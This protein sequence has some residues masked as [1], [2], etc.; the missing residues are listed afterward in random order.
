MKLLFAGTPEF[1]AR[2][3]AA[4]AESRH[5]ITAIITRPDKPGKRGRK[6]VTCAVGKLAGELHIP[7]LQ[8]DR[9]RL[10]HIEKLDA[11]LLVVVAYGQIL[12]EDILTFPRLGCINVHASLLPRWRGAAPIQRAIMAGDR[13]T[14]IC[15]MKMDAGL[16]TGD[17]Y[18]RTVV[19]ILEDDTGA[20][21]SDRL[22]GA[23]PVALLTTLDDIEQ[24]VAVAEPQETTGITYAKKISKAEGNVDWQAPAPVTARLINALNPDP[25]AY[26]WLD[27]LRVRLWQAVAGNDDPR[28]PPG[29]ILRLSPAG[30]DVACG[31]GTLTLTRIQLPLGKGS[32]LT[33]SD[34]LNARAGLL[35]PGRR[36][37]HA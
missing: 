32:I 9:L 28:A 37:S 11:D 1:A 16:D 3:L 26:S 13:E 33:G 34:V 21:L 25:V 36:F 14:G 10:G 35:A 8:P 2:H 18:R 12:R 6:P 17:I 5:H 23:G 31:E 29:T 24:G 15:I 27:A 30:I 19:P 20:S 22:A 4:L 7:L